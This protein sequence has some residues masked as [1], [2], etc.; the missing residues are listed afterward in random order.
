MVARYYSSSLGRFVSPDPASP[1]KLQGIDPESF[2]ELL[3]HPEIWN[4]YSYAL[5]NP[6]YYKD[7][8]GRTAEAVAGTL[9]GLGW[10]DPLPAEELVGAAILGTAAVVAIHQ[11]RTNKELF[12]KAMAALAAAEDQ[13]ASHPPFNPDDPNWKNVKERFDAYIKK[14]KELAEKMRGRAR[15]YKERIEREIERLIEEFDRKNPGGAGGQTPP[16]PCGMQGKCPGAPID[17]VRRNPWSR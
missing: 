16:P 9:I 1:I 11:A 4:R 8:N 3:K 5:N 7:P 15:H 10:L 17:P 12:D 2:D 14:A 6:L 13:I